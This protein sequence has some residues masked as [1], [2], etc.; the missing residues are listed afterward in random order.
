M[1]KI[2]KLIAVLITAAML[3]TL[4]SVPVSAV[5]MADALKLETIGILKGT[6][7]GVDA[8]YRAS[9]PLRYQAA[10]L[11]LRLLGR[12]NAAKSWAGTLNF[13]DANTARTALGNP[14][15]EENKTMLAYLF[16]HQN[17]GYRGYTDDTFRPFIEINAQMYYK[18]MLVAL[19]YVEGTD[20]TWDNVFQKAVQFG[21]TTTAPSNETAFNIDALA[22]ATVEALKADLKGGSKTLIEKLV[23][24]DQVIAANNAVTAGLYVNPTPPEL[25]VMG[26]SANNLGEIYVT[27]NNSIDPA[28]LTGSITVGGALA[29]AVIGASADTVVVTVP[30]AKRVANGGS[31][32]VVV[33]TTLKGTNGNALAAAYT[34]TLTVFD[35]AKPAVTA[36]VLKSPNTF[37]IRFNEI[38]NSGV[39]GLVKIDNGLYGVQSASINGKTVTV[40]T[41]SP[42]LPTGQH[43]LTISLFT[44]LA[45]FTMDADDTFSLAYTPDTT[46]PSVSVVS[47]TQTSAVF[48]FSETVTNMMV[49]TDYYHTFAGYTATAI[50]S[51]G[52]NRYNVVFGNNPMPAGTISFTVKKGNIKDLWGNT[53]A[54]DT[55]LQA[56]VTSD[57]TPPAITELKVVNDKTLEVYFSEK[58]V[59]AQATT[60]ANYVV[61]FGGAAAAAPA[62]ITYFE[63]AD[64]V[65]AR[66]AWTNSL[67]GGTYAIA[68]KNIHDVALTPNKMGDFAGTFN[69]TD[70][71][72]IDITQVKAALV[73]GVTNDLIYVRYPEAMN[74]TALDK[75]MYMIRYSSSVTAALPAAATITAFGANSY[76][77]T[78]PHDALLTTD[79]NTYLIIGRVQDAAGNAV[80]QLSFNV[81]VL[82]EARPAVVAGTLHQT[83]ANRLSVQ[84]DKVLTRV[85]RDA[86]FVRIGATD[87][88]AATV[89]SVVASGGK[90]MVTFALTGDCVT[91]IKAVSADYETN[92]SA[93]IGSGALATVQL[94]INGSYLESETGMTAA[95]TNLTGTVVDKRVPV[96]TSITVENVGIVVYAVLNFSEQITTT[97]AGFYAMDLNVRATETGALLQAGVD[98]ITTVNAGKVRIEIVGESA[99]GYYIGS[100]PTI[101][102]IQDMAGN[103]ITPFA[104]AKVQ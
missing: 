76:K 5:E 43:A 98:Y 39:A 41:S 54:A 20:F 52:N 6:G 38:L 8:A 61:T 50:T 73:T 104:Q 99:M 93:I 12:E 92:T 3:V 101:L 7:S 51:L 40:T 31:Y 74:S 42:T 15:T 81:Q 49:L 69:V 33:G 85:E 96:L 46:A 1:K 26:V 14:L 44:D 55:T 9:V 67:P 17:L 66:L 29:D 48:E 71:T 103:K 36:I 94:H 25:Q 70:V 23:E 102:Y 34:R 37:E 21:L 45:G 16:A 19:G 95:N 4:M 58:V 97:N 79:G 35:S 22:K 83:E 62:S 30:V 65:F 87:Y 28:T 90:T 10:W 13:A 88:A 78:L 57:T 2:K 68:I 60:L 86:F 27:F 80:G 72:P 64:S 11:F 18:L 91:A 63:T 75:A 47:T 56:A 77:I 84:F 89:D 32:T 53:L 82:A 59:S 24:D 100:K